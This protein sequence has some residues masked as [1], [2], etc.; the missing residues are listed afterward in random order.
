MSELNEF[1]PELERGF[2]PLAEARQALERARAAAVVAVGAAAD[3]CGCVYDVPADSADLADWKY[4]TA[5]V[6]V[7]LRE[8][9]SDI[10]ED[11][12]EGFSGP[13]VGQEDSLKALRAA[14]NAIEALE[15]AWRGLRAREAAELAAAGAVIRP[16]VMP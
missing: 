2:Y 13:T 1:F 6:E 12:E 7:D 15:T 11:V 5:A 16:E 4:V 3:Q 10:A 8:I 9:R 14:M